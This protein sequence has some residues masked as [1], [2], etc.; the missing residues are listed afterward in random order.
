MINL[1]AGCSLWHFGS[2]H[3]R[4]QSMPA[5]PIVVGENT[6][7]YF[8]DIIYDDKNEKNDVA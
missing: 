3:P 6:A 5:N 7:G 4:S 8:I 2:I 1:L